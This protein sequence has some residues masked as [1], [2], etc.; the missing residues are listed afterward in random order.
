MKDTFGNKLQKDQLVQ[1]VC[2]DRGTA[3]IKYGFIA[4]FTKQMVKVHFVTGLQT[5]KPK[6]IVRHFWSGSHLQKEKLPDI[7]NCKPK[8]ITIHPDFVQ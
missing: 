8:Y 5:R 3:H 4:G 1:V 6:S 2:P 7:K